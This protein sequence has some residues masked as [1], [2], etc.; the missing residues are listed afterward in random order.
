MQNSKSV[1]LRCL[2]AATAAFAKPVAPPDIVIAND[3]SCD[4][5]RAPD[6][7]YEPSSGRRNVKRKRNPNR[8]R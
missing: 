7:D 8:W 1:I 4:P 3:P 5:R 2:L 6:G